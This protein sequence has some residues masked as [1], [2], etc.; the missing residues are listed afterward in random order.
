[1]CVGVPGQ[2]VL[3]LCVNPIGMQDLAL[4]PC[5]SKH[6]VPVHLPVASVV[7]RVLAELR[8]V[9]LEDSSAGE[10]RKRT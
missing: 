2:Q 7:F 3:S 1:M 10:W 6:S 8:D 4:E 9:H 5:R